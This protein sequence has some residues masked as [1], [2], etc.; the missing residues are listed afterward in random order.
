MAADAAICLKGSM[1]MDLERATARLSIH[2]E[3]KFFSLENLT[4][5]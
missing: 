1:C 5:Q 3:G 2:I 4:S